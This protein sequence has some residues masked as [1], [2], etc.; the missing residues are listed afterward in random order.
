MGTGE[1]SGSSG[2]QREGFYGE[3][4]PEGGRDVAKSSAGKSSA[5]GT[6]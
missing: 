6:P 4:V 3:G 1:G 2:E 5:S